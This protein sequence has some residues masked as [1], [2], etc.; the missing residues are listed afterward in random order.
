[1][2]ALLRATAVRVAFQNELFAHSSSDLGF[3]HFFKKIRL[4]IINNGP[5][6]PRSHAGLARME[7]ESVSHARVV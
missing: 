3:S 1:M 2:R 6:T 4:I 7:Q 5:I